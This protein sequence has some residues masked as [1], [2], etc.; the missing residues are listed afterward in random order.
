MKRTVTLTVRLFHTTIRPTDRLNLYNKLQGNECVYPENLKILEEVFKKA[1]GSW[2][3][4][5]SKFIKELYDEMNQ[6]VNFSVYK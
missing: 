3:E 1:K 5:A 2:E 6:R 4:N